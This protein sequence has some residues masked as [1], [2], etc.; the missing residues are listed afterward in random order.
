MAKPKRIEIKGLEHDPD[1][2]EGCEGCPLF[3]GACW[4]APD[5]WPA[6]DGASQF[7]SHRERWT[8][9]ILAKNLAAVREPSQELLVGFLYTLMRDDV[10]PGHVEKLVMSGETHPPPYKFSNPHL[11]AY[12]REL[13]ARL[14]DH[15]PGT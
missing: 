1:R 15:E 9:G 6:M 5:L 3:D 4:A 7:G 14:C 11:E 13:A 12:A 10:V 8:V 2:P